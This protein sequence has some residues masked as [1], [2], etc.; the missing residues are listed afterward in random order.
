[1]H[2]KRTWLACSVSTIAAAAFVTAASAAMV[3]PPATSD[4]AKVPSGDFGITDPMWG[5]TSDD[6]DLLIE[7]EFGR[8]S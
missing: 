5:S 6:V 1:M 4:P 3:I 2:A 8:N 7:G